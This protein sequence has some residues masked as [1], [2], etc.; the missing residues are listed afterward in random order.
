MAREL[1]Q[2][3]DASSGESEV[4]RAIE[5]LPAEARE[6]LL[7]MP[8]CKAGNSRLEKIMYELDKGIRR[9]AAE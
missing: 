7:Q 9:G 2:S 4:K 3:G 6:V 5:T 8:A 1:A